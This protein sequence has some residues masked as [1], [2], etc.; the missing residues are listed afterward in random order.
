MGEE[1]GTVRELDTHEPL[2]NTEPFRTDPALLEIIERASHA[3]ELCGL[4]KSLQ[5][6]QGRATPT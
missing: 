6:A 1:S 5:A 2:A 3:E 4:V